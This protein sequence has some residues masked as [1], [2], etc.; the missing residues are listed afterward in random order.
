MPH[1]IAQAMGWEIDIERGTIAWSA[2]SAR[3]IGL[4]TPKPG[5]P[6]PQ[7]YSTVHP[8]DRRRV[9]RGVTRGIQHG[10]MRTSFRVVLPS[11][12]IRRVAANGIM[13]TDATNR[14]ARRMV[15]WFEPRTAQREVERSARS[16]AD[17]MALAAAAAD[18]GFWRVD[19]VTR[20]RWMSA[21]ALEIFGLGPHEMLSV[22]AFYAAVHPED[23]ERV[24]RSRTRLL[25][26]R[27]RFDEA[28]RVVRRDG[29]T[30][31]VYSIALVLHDERTDH[32]HAVGV[33]ADITTRFLAQQELLEQQRQLAHLSRIAV[34]G[35]LSGAI[36]HELS[37]PITAIVNNTRVAQHMLERAGELDRAEFQDILDDIANAGTRAGGVMQRIRDLIKNEPLVA[38]AVHL[39]DLTTEVLAIMRSELLAR[40]VTPQVDINASLPPVR[41]D[42]VQL[43]Q[44]LVNLILNACDAMAAT[45]PADRRLAI[46]GTHDDG[47]CALT[48]TDSGPGI[49]LTP[50]DR[51]FEPFVTSK[52]NGAGLGLAICRKVATAH[53]GSLWA[54]DG[55]A[56]GATFHLVLPRAVEI[57]PSTHSTPVARAVFTTH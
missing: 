2:R 51:V 52:P 37:Q 34:V 17:R 40:E 28:Y 36:T 53:G 39:G 7:F 56:G 38:E 49:A 32:D 16:R 46:V 3:L 19:L 11:G 13:A 31:W 29:T 50:K 25:A 48:I 20:K 8:A 57:P 9:R 18:V 1:S 21:F 12:T 44:V 26:E 22:N 6:L 45:A 30:R 5:I 27:R 15:G 35:E 55:P 43:Q 54:E 23:R 4:K 14:G 42:R 47:G 41:G 33:V 24:R 10:R